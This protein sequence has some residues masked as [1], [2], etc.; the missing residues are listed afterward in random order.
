MARREFDAALA[1][2]EPRLRRFTR[3][4]CSSRADADDVA[5]EAMRRAYRYAAGFDASRDPV[6][7]LQ[8]I[9]FRVFCDERRRRRRQ[10]DEVGVATLE[11]AR[12]PRASRCTAELRDEITA[13]L[14]V[15]TATEQTLLLEFHRDGYSLAELAQRHALRINTVKSHLR[16]ARRK[17]PGSTP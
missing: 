3:R 14:A 15:M 6:P 9:A 11:A 2:A 17:L 4:L 12:D 7:W 10:P 16:R 5:Q 13:A 1:A 8:R